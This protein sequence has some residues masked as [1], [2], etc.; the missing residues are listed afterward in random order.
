MQTVGYWCD[1]CRV[2]YVR[3]ACREGLPCGHDMAQAVFVYAKAYGRGGET[4]RMERGDF[5]VLL[6][7][8]SERE[9]RDNC[10]G[11]DSRELW[12]TQVEVLEAHDPS[13][14]PG[15]L[16]Y[17][18]DWLWR[19]RADESILRAF[20][21]RW[22]ST[23]RLPLWRVVATIPEDA[24]ILGQLPPAAKADVLVE[25]DPQT[26]TST[27]V[28][29]TTA[30]TR[31]TGKVKWFNDAKGFGFI[32]HDGRDIFVH[33][34]AIEGDGFKTLAEGQEVEFE[35]TQSPKGPQAE[36]VVKL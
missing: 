34:S 5:A 32:E 11:G 26:T 18:G 36:R 29:E 24:N 17:A 2:K 22:E 1:E 9:R 35:V 13:C 27:S 20:F 6:S 12:G 15:E 8:R 30:V 14:L 10:L 25:D 19:H 31:V 16:L 3:H 7:V 23:T 4:V 21:N 28:E 33:Y